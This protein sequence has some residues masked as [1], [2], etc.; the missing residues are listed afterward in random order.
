MGAAPP[1]EGEARAKATLGGEIAVRALLGV[2]LVM[3]TV[4][5]PACAGRS[6]EPGDA[7]AVFSDHLEHRIPRLIDRYGVPGASVAFVL[8]GEPVWSGAYGYADVERRRRMTIDA[9]CRAES[10]SKS[11]TAW[12]VMRPVERGLVDPDAP[13]ERY[14]GGWRLPESGYSPEEVTTR[15]LLS[16]NAGMP[17]GPI[18][19]GAEYPPSAE[20]PSLRDYLDREAR[21]MRKPGSG[22]AYSNVGFN[23]LELLIEQVTGR[24]FADYMADEVLALAATMIASALFPDTRE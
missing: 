7:V 18:G 15:R 13:V 23:L 10:I 20:M 9:I 11:V 12:G 17:L 2:L 22:F 14:L 5:T 6:C 1:G 16:G 19:K 8:E 24:G 4:A 21:P 3:G